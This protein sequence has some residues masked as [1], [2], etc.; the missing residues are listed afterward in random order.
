[1]AYEEKTDAQFEKNAQS[2]P[3]RAR[4]DKA[5]AEAKIEYFKTIEV[6]QRSQEEAVVE[7]DEMNPTGD[8]AWEALG[9]G[10][11]KVQRRENSGRAV[12][13]LAEAVILQSIEDLWNPVCRG[14][15]LLFFKGAGFI[16]YS[17]IAGISYTKQIALIRMLAAAGPMTGYHSMR[18]AL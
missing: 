10:C 8:E 12:R 6:L 11:L 17:G 4:A 14:E 18:K 1:M 5:R 7:S 3:L 2:A 9:T 16:L 13:R 15:S